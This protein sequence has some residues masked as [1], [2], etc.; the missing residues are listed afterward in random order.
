MDSVES[1]LAALRATMEGTHREIA[2]L[3]AAINRN[4]EE[5]RTDCRRLYEQLREIH[6]QLARGDARMVAIEQRMVPAE[7]TAE[8]AL[9]MATDW[10]AQ[11]RLLLWVFSAAVSFWTA[12]VATAAFLWGGRGT[13]CPAPVPRARGSA[14]SR[15]A[16][17]PGLSSFRVR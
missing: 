10:D 4:R 8:R 6:Q 9:T 5:G 17:R 3:V 2:A 13:G 15:D 11:R 16:G 12:L 7:T 1:R 14:S